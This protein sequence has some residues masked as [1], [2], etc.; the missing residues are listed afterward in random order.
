MIDVSGMILSSMARK[1]ANSRTTANDR[2]KPRNKYDREIL[3]N[4]YV[5]VYDVLDAFKTGSPAIDHAVK[6]LLAA[7]KRGDKD[8]LQDL[9]EAID[10]IQSRI[11]K[12][13]EAQ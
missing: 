11:N 3:P 1:E 13:Q 5:D 4:T 9:Q 8:E 7:G 6:K 10:S 2:S 12:L